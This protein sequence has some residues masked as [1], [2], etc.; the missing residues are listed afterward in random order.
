MML[1]IASLKMDRNEEITMRRQNVI[2]CYLIV[3]LLCGAE[4]CYASTCQITNFM[5]QANGVVNN[6]TTQVKGYDDQANE[7]IQGKIG[8]LGDINSVKKKADK[9]K[10]TKQRLE[11]AQ[12]KAKKLKAAYDKA[13]EKKAALE[14][15]I[16]RAKDKANE[17]KSAYDAAQKKLAKAKSKL[18]EGLDK[19][20]DLK[21]KVEDG[22]DKAKN[23]ADAAQSKFNSV[24]DKLDSVKSKTDNGAE[25]N[26]DIIL[27]NSKVELPKENT[28]SSIE[29]ITDQTG[30]ISTEITDVADVPFEMLQNDLAAEDISELS[31]ATDIELMEIN[32][33]QSDLSLDEQ[34]QNLDK[35][36]KVKTVKDVQISSDAKLIKKGNREKFEQNAEPKALSGNSDKTKIDAEKITTQEVSKKSVSLPVQE[37]LKD[38]PGAI[39]SETSSLK[40][41]INKRHKTKGGVN[42]LKQRKD[43]P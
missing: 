28:V 8:S 18:D 33:K 29:K 7:Y 15:D 32:E 1:H 9:V 3:S 30:A 23:V 31:E 21:D 40:N 22:I 38:K 24:Q 39:S 20:N 12:A 34:L 17:L 16:K 26:A 35:F 13:K 41:R 6:V 14:A 2:F 25:N 43:E 42:L 5:D 36:K 37:K 10:K 27:E 4:F 19:V 11:K